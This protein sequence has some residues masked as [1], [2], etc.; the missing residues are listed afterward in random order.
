MSLDAIEPHIEE[1]YPRKRPASSND[2]LSDTAS[3]TSTRFR[4]SS[5]LGSSPLTAPMFSDRSNYSF[6]RTRSSADVAKYPSSGA[7]TGRRTR[8]STRAQIPSS[9]KKQYNLSQSSPIKQEK[10]AH[11]PPGNPTQLSFISEGSTIPD[12]DTSPESSDGDPTDL[13]MHSFNFNA[14]TQITSS[15]PRTPPPGGR[16]RNRKAQNVAWS[17]TPKN[18]AEDAD[19]LMYLAASPSPAQKGGARTV[20]QPPSTPPCKSTPLPSSHMTP[21]T[22]GAAW[23]FA[24]TTPG[25]NFDFS[26][27]VNITPSPAQGAWNRTPATATRRRLNFDS[28]A[29]PSSSPNMTRSNGYDGGSATKQD[30]LGMELGEELVS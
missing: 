13:P 16:L 6:K 28:L 14:P 9:W 4:S 17:R 27:F 29:P 7:P 1:R 5:G 3:T 25:N 11:F 10:H 12:R 20:V 19:L 26:D 30:G 24:P 22:H 8:Q 15:P 18:G 23:G 2:N 21:S